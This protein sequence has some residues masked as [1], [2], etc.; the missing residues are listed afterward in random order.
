LGIYAATQEFPREQL[1]G[2]TIQIRM[3]VA[4]IPS[5]IAEGCGRDGDTDL[6]K[7]L[8]ITMGSSSE[9]KYELLLARDLR[10]FDEEA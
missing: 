1:Y 7:Y 8:R 9:L 3:A 10:Y 4:S 2:L 6:C 5:N